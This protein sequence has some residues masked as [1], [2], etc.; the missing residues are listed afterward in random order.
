LNAILKVVGCI[1]APLHA[2][3]AKGFFTIVA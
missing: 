3:A 2:A 1:G